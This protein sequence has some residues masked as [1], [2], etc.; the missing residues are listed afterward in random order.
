MSLI[1]L[2]DGYDIEMECGQ[3]FQ[4]RIG[5]FQ[6]SIIDRLDIVMTIVAEI[7]AVRLFSLTIEIL[8]IPLLLVTAHGARQSTNSPLI[9]FG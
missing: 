7:Y 5:C 4:Q 8:E 3:V 9:S 2:L 6:K 1:S